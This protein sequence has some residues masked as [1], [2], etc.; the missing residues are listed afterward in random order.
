MCELGRGGSVLNAPMYLNKSYL[1]Y[2]FIFLLKE[3]DKYSMCDFY[4]CD[5]QSNT[6][7]KV[8]HILSNAL[9]VILFKNP[10]F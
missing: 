3:Y 2:L 7:H 1:F 9:P 8:S 10:R 5:Y 4:T 6:N